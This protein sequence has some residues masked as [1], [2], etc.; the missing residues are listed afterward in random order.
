MARQESFTGYSDYSDRGSASDAEG[1]ESLNPQFDL[2][3][4]L[5]SA[6][7]VR[8]R[9]ISHNLAN[10]NTPNYRRMDVSFEEE[11]ARELTGKGRQSATPQVVMSA[12][13]A[14]RSDGNNVDIDKEIGQLNKNAMLQQTY[15]QLLGN[16]LEQM[17]LA[18][19]GS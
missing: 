17:R 2:L 11:L 15:L 19:Q 12:G 7:E 5:I 18:I 13:H 4:R 9:V 10:V 6:S 8:H 3:G 14:V 16:H 1:M